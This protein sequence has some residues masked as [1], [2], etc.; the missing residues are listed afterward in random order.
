MYG[1]RVV[2][3]EPGSK[4]GNQEPGLKGRQVWLDIKLG[5]WDFLFFLTGN[6]G[7]GASGGGK[8]DSV[9]E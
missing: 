2:L 1:S 9:I 5:N 3:G 4:A 7:R 6:H 8:K